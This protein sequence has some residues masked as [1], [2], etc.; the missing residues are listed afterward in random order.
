MTAATLAQPV[1][2]SE[3]RA[4]VV[5]ASQRQNSEPGLHTV[6][7]DHPVS[8]EDAVRLT[9]QL[10]VPI[11]EL[12]MTGAGVLGGLVPSSG[13]SPAAQALWVESA[14]TARFGRA[15]AVSAVVVEADGGSVVDERVR[16]TLTAAAPARLTDTPGG[17]SAPVT[18]LI[19]GRTIGPRQAP[20]DFDSHFPSSWV[21]LAYTRRGPGPPRRA[22]DNNFLYNA[23]FGARPSNFPDDWGLEMG[24]TLYN[25][26]LSGLPR[27][28]CGLDGGDSDDDFW[29]KTWNTNGA[30]WGT[31]VPPGSAP[32]ADYNIQ[33]DD[34]NANSLEL[35]I[36]FPRALRQGVIYVVFSE[37]GAGTQPRS[38]MSASMALKSNDCNNIGS[39]PNTDCMGLNTRRRPPAGVEPTRPLVGRGRGWTVPACF[40]NFDGS[41]A[42]TRTPNGGT[43]PGGP[44]C[45][46]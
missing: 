7:L 15:P 17:M 26:A 27:P 40:Q 4:A 14:F 38:P 11:V 1:L 46:A 42:P 13:E 9:S 5:S 20:Q 2:A 30:V 31:N 39:A 3:S 16:S 24:M 21:G 34:C 44:P 28:A 18:G 37:T 22:T 41:D 19:R 29:A 23:R 10:D 45:P 8:V 25:P 33:S 32:Y 43:V 35:G 36:G 12:R 6:E